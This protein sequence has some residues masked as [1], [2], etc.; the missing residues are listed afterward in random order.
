MTCRS[1]NIRLLPADAAGEDRLAA[2]IEDATYVGDRMDYT[3]RAGDS[4]VIV[5]CH[6]DER[7]AVGKQVNLAFTGKGIT[8]WPDD[9]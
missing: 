4:L 9:G 7:H 6:D 2:T 8:V 1:E 5:R 3:V